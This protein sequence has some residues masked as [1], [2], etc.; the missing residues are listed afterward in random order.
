MSRENAVPA[1]HVSPRKPEALHFHLTVPIFSQRSLGAPQDMVKLIALY[2]RPADPAA[3]DKHFDEVHIPL[4]RKVPGLR[5]LEVTRVT[6]API[7]ESKYQAVL[8]LYF[9]DR[10]A[11]DRSVATPEGKA[12]LRDVITFASTLLTAFHG[13]VEEA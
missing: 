8:E 12:V 4:V 6:G 2:R 13:E 3:F 9:D 11:M 1:T 5:K 7:G 10:D